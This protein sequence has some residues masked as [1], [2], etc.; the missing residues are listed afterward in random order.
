MI[1]LFFTVRKIERQKT[2]WRFRPGGPSSLEVSKPF[3]SATDGAYGSTGNGRRFSTRASMLGRSIL[4]YPTAV[5][6]LPPQSGKMLPLTKRTLETGIMYSVGFLLAYCPGFLLGAA[7][8]IGENTTKINSRWQ[9]VRFLNAVLLPLQGFFNFLIYTSPTWTKWLRQRKFCICCYSFSP[10]KFGIKKAKA[11]PSSSAVGSV[12]Q[13][14][15]RAATA[16]VVNED[17]FEDTGVVTSEQDDLQLDAGIVEFDHVV[18]YNE[19]FES[20]RGVPVVPVPFSAAVPPLT[21][22]IDITNLDYIHNTA[23]VVLEERRNSKVNT[24]IRR[25]EDSS[26][27]EKSEVTDIMFSSLASGRAGNTIQRCLSIQSGDIDVK[28]G[29]DD[30]DYHAADKSNTKHPMIAEWEGQ[31]TK[32]P[33]LADNVPKTE[34][35]SFA[36]T[37]RRV[38]LAKRIIQEGKN[39]REEQQRTSSKSAFSARSSDTR[40]SSLKNLDFLL[41]S[42]SQVSSSEQEDNDEEDGRAKDNYTKKIDGGRE[43]VHQRRSTNSKFAFR[44]SIIEIVTGR[45]SPTV[46]QHHVT[47]GLNAEDFPSS[48]DEDG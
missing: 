32:E 5:S 21:T 36:G 45:R 8:F 48:D 34:T 25:N 9:W 44:P 31:A 3:S 46:N 24:S 10:K 2:K 30:N 29:A 41:D 14:E 42:D 40:R 15:S 13:N 16:K 12:P 37:K 33:N 43:A 22:A 27:E 38:S 19:D 1:T 26:D 39:R 18:G 4:K 7:R 28:V 47:S 20:N 17:N 35:S 6:H 11:V 23:D